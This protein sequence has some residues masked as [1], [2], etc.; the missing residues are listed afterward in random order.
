MQPHKVDC[1]AFMS[2]ACLWIN[3][4]F[5]KWKNATCVVADSSNVDVKEDDY[6]NHNDRSVTDQWNLLPEDL[7]SERWPGFF[8]VLQSQRERLRF[9]WSL[10]TKWLGIAISKIIDSFFVSEQVNVVWK[11]WV[12]ASWI[13]A[14]RLVLVILIS[15]DKPKRLQD[16]QKTS[17]V[18]PTHFVLP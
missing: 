16:L 6:S 7:E 1:S 11:E 17:A 8:A 18:A 10:W 9:H 5:G 14:T 13:G 2:V 4:H 3:L 12:R 15:S